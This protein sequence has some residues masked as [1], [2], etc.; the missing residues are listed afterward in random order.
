[1]SSTALRGYSSLSK[2]TAG[3]AGKGGELGLN[4]E[5]DGGESTD[6]EEGASEVNTQCLEYREKREEF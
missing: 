6:A 4:G 3:F 1:L 2:G 5:T